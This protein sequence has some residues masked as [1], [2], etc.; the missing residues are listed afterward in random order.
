MNLSPVPRGLRPDLKGVIFAP[1]SAASI[2]FKMKGVFAVLVACQSSLQSVL[3]V[4]KSQPFLDGEG[5]G[6]FSSLTAP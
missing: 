4:E 3:T 1:G 5:Q 2:G 6:Q